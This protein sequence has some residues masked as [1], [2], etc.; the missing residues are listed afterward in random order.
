MIIMIAGT[1]SDRTRLPPGPGRGSLRS[2]DRNSDRD[3]AY[4]PF[5]KLIE[6]VALSAK[7][8]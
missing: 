1:A 7:L 3:P 2:C 5:Q 4:N 8:E 6:N